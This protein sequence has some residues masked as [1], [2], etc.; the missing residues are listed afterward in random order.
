MGKVSNPYTVNVKGGYNSY[1]NILKTVKITV[2]YSYDNGIPE[3]NTSL[4][5]NK[6]IIDNIPGKQTTISCTRF[7]GNYAHH[8]KSYIINNE[9]NKNFSFSSNNAN[10]SLTIPDND[11]VIQIIYKTYS[12][13]GVYG[14]KYSLSSMGVFLN[15]Y[16]L[17]YIN[18]YENI[19]S[20]PEKNL[21]YLNNIVEDKIP[22][23]GYGIGSMFAGSLKLKEVPAFN[24]TY[25]YNYS[26]G[27]IQPERLYENC[28]SLEKTDF[29]GNL[30]VK[31]S[32]FYTFYNCKLLKSIPLLSATSYT[33]GQNSYNISMSHTFFGCESFEEI[34]LG[35]IT[36]IYN[37]ENAFENCI[38]LKSIKI[39]NLNYASPGSY[40][41]SFYFSSTFKNCNNLIQSP[42]SARSFGGQNSSVYANEM[43]SGCKSLASAN[44]VYSTTNTTNV[45]S[46]F[47]NCI[48]LNTINFSSSNIIIKVGQNEYAENPYTY[49]DSCFEN[50]SNLKNL[51]YCNN[52]V[53]LTFDLENITIP[54]KNVF[55]NC[56]IQNIH[57]KNVLR[58]LDL[59]NIGGIE[60]ETYIID[61][62]ID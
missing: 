51:V 59:S 35:S 15:Q 17:K 52:T 26:L 28:E 22:I 18:N 33:N 60:G 56:P 31:G 48:N 45:F 62:Y 55:L 30:P 42:I 32:L 21:E 11:I 16:A 9:E 50:C 12:Y 13:D 4:P 44:F 57:L 29:C 37:F 1:A 40:G 24:F 14:P 36:S 25:S 43:Y 41:P 46:M 7:I 39:S 6:E 8:I 54:P 27:Q 58:S 23:G 47:K 10:F 61:N 53:T 5:E 20:I 34:T 19:E 3:D 38:N 2:Q 49:L